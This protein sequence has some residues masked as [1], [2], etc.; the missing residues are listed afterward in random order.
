MIEA[1]KLAYEDRAKFYADPDFAQVP[2]AELDLQAVRRQAPA[3]DRPGQGQPTSRAGRP[4]RRPT[5]FT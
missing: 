1:K 5:R 4:G 2:I 3:A